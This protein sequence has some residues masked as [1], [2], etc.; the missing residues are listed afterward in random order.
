MVKFEV[1][2]HFFNFKIF[3]IFLY[4]KFRQFKLFFIISKKPQVQKKLFR[5]LT[6]VNMRKMTFLSIFSTLKFF[7]FFFIVNLDNLNCF[8]SFS[9]NLRSKKIYFAFW[10]PTICEKWHF[11]NFEIFQIFLYCKFRQFKLFFIICKK[12]Q[13][14]K[15]L[16]SVLTTDNMRKMTFLSIFSTLKFLKFFYNV[17]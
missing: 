6:T 15:N 14:Q 1:F 13:V 2:A 9:V 4:C 17:N 11:F 8:L 7:N 5:V 3:Q 12:L 10:R 16:F